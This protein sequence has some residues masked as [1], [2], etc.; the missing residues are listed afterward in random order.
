LIGN[1]VLVWPD[2]DAGMTG[3][4][5]AEGCWGSCHTVWWA[6]RVAVL[7]PS[8]DPVL[9]FASNCG[10]SLEEISTRIR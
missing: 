10:K 8:H 3:R 9:G 7:S 1:V 2:A 5:S 4:T 6:T